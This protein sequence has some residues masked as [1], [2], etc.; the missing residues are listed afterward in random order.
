MCTQ[1]EIN[2]QT[3]KRVL[4]PVSEKFTT[5]SSVYGDLPAYDSLLKSVYLNEPDQDFELHSLAF[6]SSGSAKGRNVTC[7]RTG[8]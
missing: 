1:Q 5:E 2:T 8:S 3:F 6:Q 4:L 7:K